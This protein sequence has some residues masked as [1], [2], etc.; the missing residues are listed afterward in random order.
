MP[1]SRPQ[2]HTLLAPL[3]TNISG[4]RRG[5][6]P[7]HA[8]GHAHRYSFL[9]T[10]IEYQ[11][12]FTP[13]QTAQAQAGNLNT[14]NVNVTE[15]EPDRPL[16]RSSN[17]NSSIE[18]A[19]MET[20]AQQRTTHLSTVVEEAS[21][22]TVTAIATPISGHTLTSS[23]PAL[24]E[25]P[26]NFIPY[27]RP[28]SPVQTAR[29]AQFPP[30]TP[31]LPTSPPPVAYINTSTPRP[32]NSEEQQLRREKEWGVVPD[33]N[34]LAHMNT[35]TSTMTFTR[36]PK[37]SHLDSQ[38][39]YAHNTSSHA[40]SS[41]L[42]GQIRHP[43][44]TVKG[45]TWSHGLCDPT[46]PGTCCMGL[47][48]PCILYGKTQYRLSQKADKRDATNMLGYETCNASCT[49]MALLLC[50]CQCAYHYFIRSLSPL[51]TL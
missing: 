42:P 32:S 17:S 11:G 39:Q 2:S 48:C 34:P 5:S 51:K 47:L 26:V 24:S 35:H 49:A 37:S 16:S 18:D 46:D 13:S 1:P 22:R 12:P 19:A 43:S 23:P 4:Q 27:I 21:P 7:G 3:D 29:S 28:P 15:M 6:D 30:T 14:A 31:A 25:H 38:A 41:H 10:P 9:P 44:Q 20:T 8:H 40:H 45:G 36:N 50:G 33:D